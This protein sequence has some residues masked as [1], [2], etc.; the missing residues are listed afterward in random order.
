MPRSRR[1]W[2]HVFLVQAEALSVRTRSMATPCS[3]SQLVAQVRNAA[4]V[5]AVSSGRFRCRAGG[6][7]RPVRCAGRRNP[8]RSGC[9]VS[10]VP[11][12]GARRRRGWGRASRRRGA[13]VHRGVSVQTGGRVHRWPGPAPAGTVRC[14]V[15]GASAQPRLRGLRVSPVV[16]G[17]G[18]WTVVH[19]C[20][21]VTAVVVCPAGGG[22]ADLEAFC[23]PAHRPA[24]VDDT[25]GQA[26][27]ACRSQWG[28]TVGQR[29][30]LA[31]GCRCRNPPRTQRPSPLSRTAQGVSPVTNVPGQHT[32]PILR[33][34]VTLVPMGL[35]LVCGGVDGVGD[36]AD[37]EVDQSAAGEEAES[38][39]RVGGCRGCGYLDG[40]GA[41]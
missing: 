32:Q 28:I 41:V 10:N 2:P 3:A 35:A 14:G 17:G 36:V 25:P 39:G 15:R 29:G 31:A 9:A 27:P 13:P 6:S 34:S 40:C 20:T 24:V 11:G 23:G 21:A 37:V 16:S 1:V 5:G 26:Q 30:P 22:V 8:C 12:C 4:Q 18:D 7:D 38:G 33:R 19:A